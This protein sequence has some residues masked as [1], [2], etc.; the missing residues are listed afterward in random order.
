LTAIAEQ[1]TLQTSKR[2][3]MKVGDGII[4]GIGS[5]DFDTLGYPPTYFKVTWFGDYGTF[6]S[7]CKHLVL[8]SEAP[9]ESG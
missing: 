2:Q 4:I 8:V 6:W 7:S 5:E 9:D 1:I 3:E